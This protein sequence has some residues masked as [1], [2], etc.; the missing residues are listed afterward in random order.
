MDSSASR[1]HFLKHSIIMLMCVLAT[2]LSFNEREGLEGK[3][4]NFEEL[5]LVRVNMGHWE[6][7]LGGL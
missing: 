6:N 4:C 2:G 5:G 3:S 1:E 7:G